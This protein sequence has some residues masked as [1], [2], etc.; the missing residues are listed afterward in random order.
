MLISIGPYQFKRS[1]DF[2]QLTAFVSYYCGKRRNCN[3]ENA[4]SISGPVNSLERVETRQETRWHYHA[5]LCLVFS[6][7]NPGRDECIFPCKFA[8]LR[9]TLNP[10]QRVILKSS[11]I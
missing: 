9:R 8:D 7:I 1:N 5:E 2:R 3:K 11:K 6:T 4:K 10:P